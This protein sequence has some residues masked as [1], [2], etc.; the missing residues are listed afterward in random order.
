MIPCIFD[1]LTET[2]KIFILSPYYIEQKQNAS[3]SLLFDLHKIVDCQHYTLVLSTNPTLWCRK[4]MS[5]VVGQKHN[6]VCVFF[7]FTL[8]QFTIHSLQHYRNCTK[9][10]RNGNVEDVFEKLTDN[11]TNCRY[12]LYCFCF[13]GNRYGIFLI[14][15]WVTHVYM[16]YFQIFF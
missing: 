7:R 6:T 5:I 4:Y 1:D 10:P 11:K 3:T 12:L 15:S 2:L 13:D 16:L 8:P 14:L 9:P